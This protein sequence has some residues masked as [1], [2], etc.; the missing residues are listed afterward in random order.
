MD[1]VYR[2][3]AGL[4]VHKESV[5]ACALWLGEDGRA[6]KD[7]QTFGTMT[8]DLLALSDW[9]AER[10]VT[11]VAMESTGVFWKPIFNILED[12]FEI[13]LVNAR[14]IKQVPGRKT[15]VKDCDWIAQLLQHGL[16]K[17]SFVPERT[18]RDLRDLTRHR[19]QLVSEHTRVA[20]RIQKVLE[21]ANIKL[22]SVA[23]DVLGVSGRAMIQQLPAGQDDAEQM[24][25]LARGKLRK[26]K[27]SLSAALEGHVTEHHR[28]M[29]RTLWDH[30]TYLEKAIASLD[31]RI[32]EQMRPFQAELERL[33]AIPGVDRTVARALTAEIGFDMSR[34]PTADHLASWGGVAPGNNE[35]AGKRKHGK[36]TQGNRWLKR[37]LSQA[38]W[39]ASHTKDTYLSAQYRQIARR[40]GKR[41]AI[42]ALAH[43]IL[44]SAYHILADGA[45]YRE[46][47]HDYF[48]RLHPDR[49]REYYVRRLKT[50]GYE[51][52]LADAGEAA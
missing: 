22:S 42:I 17:A 38:A 18:Q 7:I 29:L 6:H 52:Q 25:D 24:A 8:R 37:C 12:R 26:K 21:D 13:V 28:F 10:K 34:F 40:R 23:T 32:E 14:H 45:E 30:L 11:H 19:A 20:N 51:V 27:A 39:A 16:L 1:V 36:T 5:A 3:C 15:D 46:L 9:L 41:R 35:S 31:E 43:T 49:L 47:G 48:D 4:D 33:D 50:L 44:I 2:C